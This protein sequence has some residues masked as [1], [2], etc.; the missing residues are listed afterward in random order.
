MQ[1]I[2]TLIINIMVSHVIQDVF[3]CL[4]QLKTR[5]LYRSLGFSK[6][7]QHKC[8]AGA[9][10]FILNV[11]LLKICGVYIN[12]IF[13]SI[14]HMEYWYDIFIFDTHREKKACANSVIQYVRCVHRNLQELG[15]KEKE[16]PTNWPLSNR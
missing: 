9:G 13:L 4:S 2:V 14:F 8:A 6:Y 7:V 15:W 5:W 12:I 11:K 3:F 1:W 10:V 16:H